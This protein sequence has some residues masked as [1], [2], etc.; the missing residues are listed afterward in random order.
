MER[1]Q[2]PRQRKV[3]DLE[4]GLFIV[5][6]TFAED[7]VS[8]PKVTLAVADKSKQFINILS[9]PDQ[10]EAVLWHPGTAL[11]VQALDAGR[12]FL[13]VIAS[14]S[15]GSVA[16]TIRIESLVQRSSA[17]ELAVT[18]P[19]QEQGFE[20][21]QNR[22]NLRV[23]G[24]VAGR[25]DVIVSANEWIAGPHAPSRIE[26]IALD[27]P[28]R[29]I[30]LTIQYAVKLAN[31]KNAS[32]GL[33]DLG[34]FTGTRGRS[35]PLVAAVFELSGPAASEYEFVAQALFLGSPVL[36]AR[37]RRLL[38]RGASGRE[39]LVGIRLD[40]RRATRSSQNQNRVRPE[41]QQSAPAQ[42]SVFGNHQDDT[43]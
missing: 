20:Q 14:R 19:S 27:W 40:I 24:H 12:L 34:A 3:L 22:A 36:P 32:S 13:E 31:S 35:A 33:V 18:G 37:G 26:G 41:P 43:T 16:A 23:L 8:P 6:Y 5:R 38:L 21:S 28:D 9:H 30:G 10:E 42:R 29:P 25:G 4:R 15:D 2:P 1:P 7:D 17:A 11:A 39:P